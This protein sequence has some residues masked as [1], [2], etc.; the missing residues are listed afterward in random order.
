MRISFENKV[1]LVTAA[2]MG[3]GWRLPRLLPRQARQS[4]CPITTMRR[5]K[6]PLTS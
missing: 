1:A 4:S 2:A 5:S 3:M 6:P